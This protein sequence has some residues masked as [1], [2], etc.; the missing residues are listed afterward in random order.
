MAE[1]V[2]RLD[3]LAIELGET[4]ESIDINPLIAMTDRAVAVDALFLRRP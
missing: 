4:V 3:D 2:Q 1:A